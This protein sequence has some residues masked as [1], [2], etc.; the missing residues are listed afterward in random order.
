M[1]WPYDEARFA[2]RPPAQSY[3]DALHHQ[4][5]RYQRVPVDVK[6]VKLALRQ[7]PI[8]VGFTVGAS[9]ESDQVAKTGIWE[10]I[11]GERTVGGHA[12]E[13]EGWEKLKGHHGREYAVCPNSWDDDWGDVGYVHI[14]LAWLC[15]T[16][17]ADDFWTL[18]EV[19]R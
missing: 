8:V 14:P 15:N 10:P 12:I 11:D 19:E 1:D 16:N 6:H 4:V 2:D 5:V 17:H 18:T 3:A 9:F 13:V 7:G